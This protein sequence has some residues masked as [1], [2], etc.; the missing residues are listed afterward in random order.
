MISIQDPSLVD[1]TGAHPVTVNV[2]Q[3]N[4]TVTITSEGIILDFWDDDSDGES[5]GT[6]GMTFDE[7]RMM[8]LRRLAAAP[9][10]REGSDD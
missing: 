6:I 5:H 10:T 4:M 7:W 8:A 3:D 2:I 9:I 1:V